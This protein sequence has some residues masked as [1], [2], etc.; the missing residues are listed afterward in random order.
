MSLFERPPDCDSIAIQTPPISSSKMSK[1]GKIK[2]KMLHIRFNLKIR[3]IKKSKIDFKSTGSV[4]VSLQ[5]LV[6]LTDD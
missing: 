2:S 6:T 3:Y 5:P 4:T 1:T